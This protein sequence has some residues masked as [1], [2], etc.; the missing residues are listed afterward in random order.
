[1]KFLKAAF[2]TEYLLVTTLV[3]D[4]DW[5]KWEIELIFVSRLILGNFRMENNMLPTDFV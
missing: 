4:T 3:G 5:S 1:M 2:L